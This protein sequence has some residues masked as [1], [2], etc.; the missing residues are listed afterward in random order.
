MV[1]FTNWFVHKTNFPY[2]RNS[3]FLTV[4]T[5]C[6][7]LSAFYYSRY[8]SPS[9]DLKSKPGLA[10]PWPLVHSLSFSREWSVW[11]G[12]VLLQMDC[13]LTLGWPIGD[14]L[15]DT[16]PWHGKA[17]SDRYLKLLLFKLPKRPGSSVPLNCAKSKME[18][19]T[20]TLNFKNQYLESISQLNEVGLTCTNQPGLMRSLNKTNCTVREEIITVVCC[21]K[22]YILCSLQ[23]TGSDHLPLWFH[24]EPPLLPLGPIL[25]GSLGFHL[26]SSESFPNV[27]EAKYSSRMSENSSG[28]CKE[29]LRESGRE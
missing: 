20:I 24:R 3:K 1:F 8:A 21:L 15:L 23:C 26:G 7:T 2:L 19:L 9:F 18:E 11:E 4:L 16:N 14:W 22:F 28:H 17:L 27:V 25:T 12:S 13:W 29:V 6:S 5:L 10:K